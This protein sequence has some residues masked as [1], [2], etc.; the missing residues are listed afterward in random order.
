MRI[1]DINTRIEGDDVYLSVKVDSAKLG[2]RELWFSTPK[3]YSDYLCTDQYDGFLVGLL[4]PA[5]RYAEN[6]TIE[7]SISQKLLFNINKYVIPLIKSFSSYAQNIEVKAKETSDLRFS[8]KGVGTGFSGGIDS[9]CTLYEH[10]EKE[11]NV[12]QKINSFLFLNVGSNGQDQIQSELKFHSRY[13]YLSRLPKELGI[14]FI[15]LNSNLH[16][17]HP[18][19]HQETHTLTSM[20]GVLVL[21]KHFNTYFYSSAGLNYGDTILYSHLYKNI[22]IGAYCDATLLPML[23]TETTTLIADGLAYSRSEK[24]I[25]IAS[26][27]PTYRFLNVC[28]SGDDTYENCS[29]CSKCLR[30]LLALDLSGNIENYSHL[31]DLKKYRKLRSNYI[32]QQV[33]NKNKDAFSKDIV[34]YAE[35]ENL[36]LPSYLYSAIFYYP[37]VKAKSLVRKYVKLILPENSQKLLNKLRR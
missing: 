29:S 27:E 21:Q 36:K 15:P 14:D 4:Y 30:T 10:Y 18:W 32:Y 25:N 13:T 19:G 5:M 31:F 7:G 22:D 11:D 2:T 16:T 12:N 34:M 35:K 37:Q 33:L 20:A 23:S 3:E 9:F 26:Y 17:F 8:A 24:V 28:V 1:Y 6:I